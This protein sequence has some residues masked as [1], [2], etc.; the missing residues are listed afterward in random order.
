MWQKLQVNEFNCLSDLKAPLVGFSWPKFDGNGKSDS[1]SSKASD[2][3]GAQS[4]GS[5]LMAL[6]K[7]Y[8]KWN[9]FVCK[10][11]LHLSVQ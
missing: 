5:S 10:K 3:S 7:Y 1:G 2:A 4:K 11:K 8:Q 9:Q 6:K